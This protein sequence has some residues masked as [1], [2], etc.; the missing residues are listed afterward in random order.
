MQGKCIQCKFLF[1]INFLTFDCRPVDLPRRF[2]LEKNIHAWKIYTSV[3]CELPYPEQLVTMMIFYLENFLSQP[4][5]K[6]FIINKRL[7]K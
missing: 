5:Q 2:L 4:P 7:F 6:I 1:V 3:L